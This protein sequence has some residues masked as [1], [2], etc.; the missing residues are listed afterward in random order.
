MKKQS[1]GKSSLK[2]LS[3]HLP[4]RIG[5]LTLGTSNNAHESE[6]ISAVNQLYDIVSRDYLDES[7]SIVTLRGMILSLDGTEYST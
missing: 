2:I 6:R 7:K 4:L 1:K 5:L 3:L